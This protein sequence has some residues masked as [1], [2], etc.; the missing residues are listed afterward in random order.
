M[1]TLGPS[2]HIYLLPTKQHVF[3]Q[4]TYFLA[5]VQNHFNTIVKRFRC[6]HG[7]NF[8][9]N[10]IISLLLSKD[11]SQHS[12]LVLVLLPRMAELKENIDNYWLLMEY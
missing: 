5:Y 11:I 1:T 8:F 3:H 4:I 6:D 9:K 7:T 2:G 12:L 10:S